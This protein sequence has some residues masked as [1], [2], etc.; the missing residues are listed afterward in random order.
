MA[1][2]APELRP[3]QQAMLD[4]LKADTSHEAFKRVERLSDRVWKL[5][6]DDEFDEQPHIYVIRGEDKLVCIDTGTGRSDL[7]AYLRSG[8]IPEL[9]GE[10]GQLLPVLVVNSH[11]HF[12]HVG[13]NFRFSPAEGGPLGDVAGLCM[14]GGDRAFSEAY[15]SNDTSLGKS[16]GCVI[17]DFQVTRW[18]AEGEIIPLTT[19]SG[20]TGLDPQQAAKATGLEVLFLPGHTPD[21]IALFLRPEGRLFVGDLLYPHACI[22]LNLPGSS[23]AD[24][25]TSTAKL[26]AFVGA[27]EETVSPVRLVSC[28]HIEHNLPVERLREVDSLVEGMVAGDAPFQPV[29]MFDAGERR[30]QFSGSWFCAVVREGDS[31]LGTPAL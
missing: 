8:A 13:S 27:Q 26:R 29:R 28:G 23:P 17:Q 5:V 4:A 12:D 30:Y 14:G 6:E 2:T 20:D 24:F 9:V 25:A 16:A 10:D 31:S 3:D 1:A 7:H 21:S 19:S 15:N 22:Y 11:C 18:L